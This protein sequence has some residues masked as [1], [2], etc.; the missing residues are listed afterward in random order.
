MVSYVRPN[1]QALLLQTM[2]ETVLK[3]VAAL[4]LVRE[5]ANQYQARTRGLADF[6]RS[7]NFPPNLALSSC[8]SWL[9]A[10]SLAMASFTRVERLWPSPDQAVP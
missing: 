1:S 10:P 9:L 5:S 3:L 7:T 4:E 8:S 6:C 2:A